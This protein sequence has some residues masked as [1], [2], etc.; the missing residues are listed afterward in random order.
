[1]A[2]TEIITALA[3]PTRRAVLEALRAGPR[4]V[5]ALAQGRPVSRPAISQHLRVLEHAGLVSV[6]AQGNQR[7]YAIRRDG[8]AELRAYLDGFW[9]EALTAYSAEIQR[10]FGN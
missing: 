2:Y 10:R 7:I 6:V 9:N 5:G 4:S 1:M 3:D 8:L